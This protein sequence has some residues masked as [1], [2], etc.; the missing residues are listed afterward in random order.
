MDVCNYFVYSFIFS[1]FIKGWFHEFRIYPEALH[2]TPWMCTEGGGK[3]FKGVNPRERILSRG[4]KIIS[5]S[6][7]KKYMKS[8]YSDHNFNKYLAEN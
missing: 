7:T 1:S 3:L 2:V 8:K 6:R 5:K 4:S